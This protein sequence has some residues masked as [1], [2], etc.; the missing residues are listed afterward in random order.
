M[1][2]AILISALVFGCIL[3]LRFRVFI[4]GPALLFAAISTAA[5]S[6]ANG[7]GGGK[8]VLAVFAVMVSVQCGYVIGLGTSYVTERTR[9][10]IRAWK[11]LSYY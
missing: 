6:F 9:L 3:G 10:P 1:I 7:F 11:P 2:L 5:L 8:I 4:L